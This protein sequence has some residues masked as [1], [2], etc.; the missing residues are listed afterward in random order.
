MEETKN[1]ITELIR[2]S[3]DIV[4]AFEEGEKEAPAEV[5]VEEVGRKEKQLV[6]KI[7]TKEQ[8]REEIIEALKG[9][10][11]AKPAAIEVPKT[12]PK[13]K[14]PLTYQEFLAKKR[15]EGLNMKQI[16]KEWKKYKKEQGL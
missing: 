1:K 2:K 14:K 9:I 7:R 10:G 15:K 11:K 13:K 4:E 12:K 8:E 3:K 16:G 5:D 6:Q